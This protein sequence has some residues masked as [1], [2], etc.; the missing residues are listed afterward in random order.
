M[1]NCKLIGVVILTLWS[2]CSCTSPKEY[3]GMGDYYNASL[4]SIKKLSSRPSKK[5]ERVLCESYPKAIQNIDDNLENAVESST[6]N[7]WPFLDR[8]L[9]KIIELNNALNSSRVPLKIDRQML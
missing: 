6:L 7:K 2:S 3:L 8:E 4:K 9:R 1:R 5:H